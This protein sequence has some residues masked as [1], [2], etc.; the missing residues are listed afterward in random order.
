MKRF[1]CLLLLCNVMIIVK[2]QTKSI[3]SLEREKIKEEIKAE[4]RAEIASEL[5]KDLNDKNPAFSL[6]NFTLNGYGAI[7][8]FNNK[9]DTNPYLKNQT[10]LERLNLYLGYRF[11]DWLSMRSEIE[12]EH[13]G[14]GTT[15]EYDVDEEAGE[16]EQEIEQ[17]GEVN[18]EQLY[19]NFD[20]KKWMKIKLGRMK[21]H[22]GLA[23]RLDAPTQYFTAYRP[24][25]EN[26]MLPLGWYENGIQFYGFIDSHW[27][28]EL[29]FTNGLDSS[30]FSSK[31]WIKKGQQ[32]KFEMANAESVAV[33]G[34]INYKFGTHKD[35]YAGIY[36]YINDANANRPKKNE[37][38]IG[39]KKGYVKIIGAYLTYNEKRLRFNTS[40]LYG[41]IQNSD[42]ISLANKYSPKSL[43]NKR[44][45]VGKNA[46][47]IAAEIGYDIL[48]VFFKNT[49][50]ALY[51]FIR[52]D[53]YNTMQGVEG[54]YV[55][56]PRWKRNVYTA[57]I[58]WLVTP[59]VVLKAHF[60]TR[61]LGSYKQ[62]RN[63]L[64]VSKQHEKENTFSL[65]LGFK[66]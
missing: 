52:Y 55:K 44:T 21:I 47:G 19:I 5:K 50:Q 39:D 61:V 29:S 25:M 40:F 13:G 11:N 48:P 28:Y 65:G 32:T 56:K 41:D 26:T 22:I 64:A 16:F 37:L 62:D 4:L 51:P 30:E 33:S 63:T 43:G 46:L 20:I 59:Q 38:R 27:F 49:N 9:Y 57:G 2:S 3:D 10:D 23:Q 54:V 53:Y 1:L 12:F 8:Y 7:N 24:E 58:N 6:K 31:N 35:T 14:V 60:A 36:A 15:M 45:P 18:L 42:V 34:A 66:F 17:G